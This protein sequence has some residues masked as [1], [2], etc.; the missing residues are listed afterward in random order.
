MLWATHFNLVCIIWPYNARPPRFVAIA[1]DLHAELSKQLQVYAS[2]ISVGTGSGK[3]LERANV[4]P[5]E[6]L[7]QLGCLKAD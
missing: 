5:N 1:L 7:Q 4:T 6:L 2:C 3:M